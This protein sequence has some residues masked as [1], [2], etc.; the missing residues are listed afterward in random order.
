MKNKVNKCKLTILKPQSLIAKIGETV[1][2]SLANFGF[3]PYGQTITGTIQIPYQKNNKDQISDGC[4]EIQ[5]ISNQETQ[6][7]SQQSIYLIQRGNCSFVTKAKNAELAGVGLLIIYDNY[8]NE[9]EQD[10]ILM[11]DHTGKHL[12]ISTLFIN[13]SNGEQIQNFIL[14][15]PNQKVDIKVEFE[16]HKEANNINVVFWMSSLDQ[17][18]YQFIKNFKKHY[19]AIQLEGFNIKFQ[20]HFALT[21]DIESRENFYSLTKDNCVSNGRYCSPELKDNDELTSSVVLE[22]LRQ[23]IISKLYPKLWWDY[24]I[25]FGDVCLNSKSAR[26]LEICSYKSMENVGFKEEQIEAVKLQFEKSFIK[27]G[28]QPINY[29]VN[30]NKILS[31]ELLTFFELEVDIFPALIVNQDFFRG[32]ITAEGPIYEFICDA[33]IDQPLNC[34]NSFDKY[35]EFKHGLFFLFQI[36]YIFFYRL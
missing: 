8:D 31:A 12:V 21:Y 27:Q 25:D 19:D 30:D 16:Q 34:F 17:D 29:A 35:V 18:S 15:N 1:S 13:K 2:Y 10:I 4:Q 32:D 6:G 5:S 20:V 7:F 23:I 24:A 28:Y 36:K 22:D 3:Q 14:Q 11:D 26:E 33:F 9:S